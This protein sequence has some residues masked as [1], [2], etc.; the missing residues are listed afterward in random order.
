MNF[1]FSNHALEEMQRRKIP[2]SLVEAVLKDP[3]QILEQSKDITIY[4]SQ[5]DFG[6]AKIYLIRVFI[7]TTRNP[8]IIVTVYRTSQIQ[9]YWSH[10]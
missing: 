3:Q 7:N 10:P 6:T 2:I 1:K 4:Q 5:L 8:V 9:K